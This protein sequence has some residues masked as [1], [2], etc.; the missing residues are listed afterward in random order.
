[1]NGC[2]WETPQ[3]SQV[4]KT[5]L[6]GIPAVKNVLLWFQSPVELPLQK[7]KVSRNV[8]KLEGYQENGNPAQITAYEVDLDNDGVAD[9]VKWD[10]EQ[11]FHSYVV[12]VNINGEWYPFEREYGEMCGC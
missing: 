4:N 5:L 2:L 11:E 1:M 7:A 10:F 12:F 9:F 8:K 6:S 3:W